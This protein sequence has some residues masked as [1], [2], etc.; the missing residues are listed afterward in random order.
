[1]HPWV[2]LASLVFVVSIRVYIWG[3]VLIFLLQELAQDLLV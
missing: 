2:Y 3:I 1:M